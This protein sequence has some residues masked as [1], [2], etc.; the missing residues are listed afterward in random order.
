M[1][2]WLKPKVC[3]LAFSLFMPLY[4]YLLTIF[5]LLNTDIPFLGTYFTIFL[6]NTQQ[7]SVCYRYERVSAT[8]A[9]N[10]LWQYY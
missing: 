9:I 6:F 10:A 4:G 1:A 5:C 2:F 8:D 3:I 7:A